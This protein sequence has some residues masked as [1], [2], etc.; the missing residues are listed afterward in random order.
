MRLK[1]NKK[2]FSSTLDILKRNQASLARKSHQQT[3]IIEDSSITIDSHAVPVRKKHFRTINDAYL[4]AGSRII[5][6]R[7][8]FSL[9]GEFNT[10]SNKVMG[11]EH[12]ATHT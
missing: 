1:S 3:S 8:F 6:Q 2:W 4:R 5:L 9:V 10:F 12:L 7:Q 11:N